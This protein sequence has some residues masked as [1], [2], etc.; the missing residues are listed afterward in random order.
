[1]L[2][3]KSIYFLVLMPL[4]RKGPCC[5]FD[6]GCA[7]RLLRA[8]GAPR[9]LPNLLEGRP[10]PCVMCS[11]TVPRAFPLLLPLSVPLQQG[12]TPLHAAA[13]NGHS[14]A[15][16]TLL[17]ALGVDVGAKA[18]VRVLVRGAAVYTIGLIAPPYHFSTLGGCVGVRHPS[19]IRE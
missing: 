2:Q 8:C 10:L 16:R 7:S 19:S 15:I 14:D 6:S 5:V 12:L 18:T 1:M 11:P 4:C 3:S 9:P 17:A 13:I